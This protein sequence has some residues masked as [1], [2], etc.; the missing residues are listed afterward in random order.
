MLKFGTENVNTR[1]FYATAAP[2]NIKDVNNDNIV[3]SDPV[4]A[5]RGKDERTVL[6]YKNGGKIRHLAIITPKK[7]YSK[8]ASRYNETSALTMSFDISNNPEWL[9]KFNSIM[10]TVQALK[11]QTFSTQPVK[12][13]KYITAKV[14]EWDGK[15]KTDFHSGKVPLGESCECQ[16]ILKLSGIYK[17][18]SNHHMQI[19]L[20]ECKY[21]TVTLRTT[22][23]LCDSDDECQQGLLFWNRL[24]KCVI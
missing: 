10:T 21:Q 5:N 6:G 8:G 9:E 16:A 15:V 2:L 24:K 11:L 18:G 14:K 7:L 12:R 13:G 22:R 1:D 4:P 17:Q 23:Y 3:L 19:Y 20:N